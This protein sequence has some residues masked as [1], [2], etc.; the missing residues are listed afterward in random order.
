MGAAKGTPRKF[1]N[2]PDESS[3]PLILPDEMV[4]VTDFEAIPQSRVSAGRRAAQ[5]RH[6]KEVQHAALDTTP[7][8]LYSGTVPPCGIKWWSKSTETSVELGLNP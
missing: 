2:R 6:R 4:A 1:A 3:L 8:V 5:A 7:S